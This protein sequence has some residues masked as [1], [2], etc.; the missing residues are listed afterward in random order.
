MKEID[1]D[2]SINASSFWY[3]G[4]KNLSTFSATP[5]T[6]AEFVWGDYTK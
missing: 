1:N 4:K 5:A 3:S 6:E 2:S